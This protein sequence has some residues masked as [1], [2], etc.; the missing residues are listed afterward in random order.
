MDS[1]QFGSLLP[2]PE[3]QLSQLENDTPYQSFAFDKMGKGRLFYD[4]VVCKATF[5]LAPG[6][7]QEA[8]EP[9]AIALADDYWDE[10]NA[11]FSSLKVAGDVLLT[12]PGADVLVTGTARSLHGRPSTE[13]LAGLRLSQGQAILAEHSM[14]L[15]GPRA[16]QHRALLGWR[17]SSSQATDSV[18]LR[19]ELAYGGWHLASKPKADEP[20]QKVFTRNPAGCGYW[21]P[22]QLDK[23]L[24]H[25]APQIVVAELALPKMGGDYPLAAPGPVARF[26]SDRT[27][28]GGTYDEAWLEQYQRSPI[29]DYPSDFDP[30][31]FQCAHP[32]LIVPRPLRGDE[33]L[34]L[35]GLLPE[36]E[37]LRCTLP[38]IGIRA[39]LIAA[40]GRGGERALQLDTLHI[41]LDKQTIALTWRLTL[42]QRAS[43]E[44]VRLTKVPI[45]AMEA[46]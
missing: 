38:G 17:L 5:A 44:Q 27:Q 40:D 33:H 21:D 14:M 16:W 19:H 26:W 37:V 43:I 32:N 23:A 4:V 24:Q 29:P 3:P 9:E 7:L 41:N 35:V 15:H 34:A 46:V 20:L 8:D 18:A 10:E 36:R 12:K 31:F 25:P 28:Y 2:I 13:W 39:E 6:E 1:A 22:E 42:D 11:E 45:K 30:R